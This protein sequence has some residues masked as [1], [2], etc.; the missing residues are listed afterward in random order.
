VYGDRIHVQ[1]VLLNLLFNG[2]DAMAGIPER[3]RRILVT[4]ATHESRK[5]MVSVRDRGHGIPPDLLDRIF[6]S[7][8]TTKKNGMGMGLSIARSLVDL[9]R[10]R[11][12]AENA[13]DGGA[14]FRFTL[15]VDAVRSAPTPATS[16]RQSWIIP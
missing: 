9:H 16:P 6:D 4:S 5:V 15:S 8:F 1:Q 11:I 10:G 13:P 2:M 14:T 7:F 12:W 3:E